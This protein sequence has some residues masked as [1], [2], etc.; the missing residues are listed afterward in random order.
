M[1]RSTDAGHFFQTSAA[2]SETARKSKKSKNKSGN[3]IKLPSKILALC[4]DPDDHGAIYAAE[5][6]GTVKRVVLETGTTSHTYRPNTS[7]LAPLTCLAIGGKSG[8]RKLY[9]GCWDKHIYSWDIASSSVISTATKRLSGHTD[10]VKAVLSIDLDGKNLLVSASADATLIVWEPSTDSRLATLKGHSRGVQAL[11]LESVESSSENVQYAT[12]FS[13][14]SNREIRRWHI[15]FTSSFEIPTSGP[16]NSEATSVDIGPLVVHETSIYTLLFDSNLDLY[17][18]SADKT[19]KVLA[20]NRN[21][22]A[23]TTLPHPDFVRGVAID[24]QGG[25]IITACRDEEVRV[26]DSGTGELHHVYSGHY[27]E[28]TGVLV[29]PGAKA[30]SVSIDGTV[31]QWSLKPQDLERAREAA[32]TESL[33][34]ADEKKVEKKSLMTA[35]EEAELAELLGDS[36]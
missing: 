1:S 25:W 8:E 36:D 33:E 5:A 7:Q 11:A 19:S 6:A 10:F 13:G 28:V 16:A 34:D 21:W 20:R 4:A 27:E 32:R 31:R 12:I 18:A 3:P 2:L 14:D 24:E 15:S 17:T 23:D 9:A 29:L 35:E 26:W 30:V 22:E